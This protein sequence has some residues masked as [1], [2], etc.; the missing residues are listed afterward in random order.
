MVGDAHPTKIALL[1]LVQDVIVEK[2]QISDTGCQ[3]LTVN[4]HHKPLIIHA[5]LL[6]L[7][8]EF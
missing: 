5:D 1:Q 3:L 7:N 6:I 2:R 8:S 4:S